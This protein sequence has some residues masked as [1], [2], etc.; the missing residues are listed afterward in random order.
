MVDILGAITLSDIV[1]T[2][3]GSV[4]DDAVEEGVDG[5]DGAGGA[6]GRGDVWV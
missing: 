1:S 4:M 6:A 2:S 3:L 5:A